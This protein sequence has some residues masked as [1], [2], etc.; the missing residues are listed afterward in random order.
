MV[1]HGMV[2]SWVTTHRQVHRQLAVELGG[3]QLMLSPLLEAKTLSECFFKGVFP[4][5]LPADEKT[6]RSHN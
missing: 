4:Q 5:N 1:F 3:P 6:L 2:Q